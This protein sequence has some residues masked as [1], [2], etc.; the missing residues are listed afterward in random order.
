[1]SGPGVLDD[2]RVVELTVWVQGP[3]AGRVLADLGAEVIKVEPPGGDPAS[4]SRITLS[5]ENVLANGLPVL[6]NMANRGKR[7][8]SLDLR[9]PEGI[10]VLHRLVAQSDVFLTNLRAETLRRY[11]CDRDMLMGIN[12]RLV[13]TRGTGLGDDGPWANRP[14][15]DMI[16]A[17]HAGFLMAL[18]PDG[19]APGYL[20]GALVDVTAGTGL[21]TGI[22]A[23]LRRRDRTGEGQTVTCSQLQAMLWTLMMNVGMAANRGIAFPAFDRRAQFNPLFNLYR[24]GDG[25][26]F[27]LSLV[28]T[29]WWEP[30][31]QVMA[32]PELDDERFRSV[33]TRA[34]HREALTAL[35]DRV[36]ATRPRQEWLDLFAGAGLLVGQIN[37]FEDL[38]TDPQVLVNGYLWTSDDGVSAPRGIFSIDGCP[39]EP[40]AAPHPGQDSNAVLHEVLGMTEADVIALRLAE[41]TW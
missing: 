8:L 22:L 15:Q 1:M 31:R 3:V 27:V 9:R 21:A 29:K 28:E 14:V 11:G 35:L 37:R 12:P 30:F 32:C 4:R 40:G 20:P 39:V 5:T 26:W 16:G 19:E 10:T 25:K 34:E 7:S 6:Y 38:G 33:R 2:I 36:F 18:S 23:A 17:G 13:Y 24:A 41:V